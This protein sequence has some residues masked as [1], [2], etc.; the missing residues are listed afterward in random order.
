MTPAVPSRPAHLAPGS[1]GT[2]GRR[3]W[4]RGIAALAVAAVLAVPA[5]E[6]VAAG[7]SKGK[8]PRPKAPVVSRVED[9]AAEDS[10]R[11]VEREAGRRGWAWGHAIHGLIVTP[12]KDG[13]VTTVQFQRGVITAV[14]ATSVTVT[15]LDKAEVTW[16]INSG[17]AV[18]VPRAVP[19]RHRK[20]LTTSTSAPTA[21]P[22]AD[23]TPTGAAAVTAVVGVEI[24][25]A[26]STTSTT[27]PT[28]TTTT[29]T[30]ATTG[31]LT[32]GLQVR[33]WGVGD[34]AN[35]TARLLMADP[36]APRPTTRSTPTAPTTVPQKD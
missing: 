36:R 24:T 22:N 26:T 4:G 23:P 34:G 3:R 25:D 33:V 10:A 15:S 21:A 6:A 18:I 35:P 30:P 29:S 19:Q 16:T 17:T 8:A 2:H 9:N 28:T 7:R 32:M 1:N 13:G 31:R 11:A 14:T 27:T 5:T 20:P 12:A